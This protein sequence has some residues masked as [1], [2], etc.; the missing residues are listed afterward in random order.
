MSNIL[1]SAI[2]PLGDPELPL[3]HQLARYFRDAV[4]RQQWRPGE[5][6]PSE[7]EIAKQMGVAV[8]TVRQAL[9]GLV[10]DGI[11]MRRQGKGTFVKQRSFDASLF[12]FW[13]FDEHVEDARP[14]QSRI[15]KIIKSSP[16]P[17]VASQLKLK[18]HESAVFISRQRLRENRSIV[19]EEIWLPYRKFSELLKTPVA[20]FGPLLYPLYERLCN[21]YVAR[22]EEWLTAEA[23]TSERAQAVDIEASTTLIVITRLASSFDGT[24]LEWRVSWGNAALFKYRT[25]IY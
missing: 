11:L 13:R 23:A 18:K 10:R 24:P 15:L 5:Q 4:S 21:Q 1:S 20:G 19:A 12:R 22:A 3:Y 7:Q 25:E 16:P 8:G 9:A 17:E 2:L 6:L 14:P